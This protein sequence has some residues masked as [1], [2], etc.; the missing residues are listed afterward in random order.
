MSAHDANGTDV[1]VGLPVFAWMGVIGVLNDALD[2]R[3]DIYGP[4]ALGILTRVRFEVEE[5]I[6]EA[7]G[8]EGIRAIAAEIEAATKDTR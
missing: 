4:I 3:D 2:N 8:E 5:A 6:F 1:S 7:V